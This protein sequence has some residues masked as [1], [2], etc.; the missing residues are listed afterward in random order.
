MQYIT[1]TV[2]MCSR[3]VQKLS[4][5]SSMC[6]DDV[7][8][9][10][11]CD[12]DTVPYKL[13]MCEHNYCW[14]CLEIQITVA[15]QTKEFPIRCA[16][17][18]CGEPI[19][20]SD[21]VNVLEDSP[22]EL[23]S[24]IHSSLSLY[25]AQNKNKYRFCLSPDC[26][27]IYSVLPW[28]LSK[29]YKCP[30]CDIFTCRNCHMSHE[31]MTCGM[32]RAQTN[33]DEKLDSWIKEDSENRAYCPN[34]GE[35]LEKDGGCNRIECCTCKVHICWVCKDYFADSAICYQHLTTIHGGYF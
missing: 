13:Q 5:S 21:I 27:M 29:E 4:K 6:E 25:V 15:T 14:S 33:M 35:G 8:V 34:C 10:C 30:L 1:K 3:H 19:T 7:C 31:G 28:S 11:L 26:S 2:E 17:E 22:E 32:Y 16:K 24:L 18:E 20:W 12:I 23:Q 9:A